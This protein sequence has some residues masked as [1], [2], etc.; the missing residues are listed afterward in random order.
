MKKN[1]FKLSELDKKIVDFKLSLHIFLVKNHIYKEFYHL[2]N[3]NISEQVFGYVKNI[4][5]KVDLKI[6]TDKIVKF[7]KTLFD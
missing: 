6:N 4:L 1:V 2:L 3:Q 5:D 7:L